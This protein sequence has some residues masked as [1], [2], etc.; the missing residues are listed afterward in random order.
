MSY[1][2]KVVVYLMQR[3]FEKNVL[4]LFDDTNSFSMAASLK[5]VDSKGYYGY[6]SNVFNMLLD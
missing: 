1:Y 4:P 6:N 3:T 2:R 5:Y